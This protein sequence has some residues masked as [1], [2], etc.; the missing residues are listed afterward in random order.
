M[1]LPPDPLESSLEGACKKRPLQRESEVQFA[2]LT[3]LGQS[4]LSQKQVA[5]PTPQDVSKR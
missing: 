1:A 5:Q 3:S 4:F 2:N